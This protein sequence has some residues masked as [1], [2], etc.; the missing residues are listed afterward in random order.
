MGRGPRFTGEEKAAIWAGVAEGL[1]LEAVAA[2]MGRSESGIRYVVAQRGGVAPRFTEGTGRRLSLEEREEISRGLMAG[3]S[4][5]AIARGLERAVSTVSREVAANGGRVRYRACGA[6]RAACQRARRP[7]VAKLA[8][9]GPLRTAVEAMLC[10]RF[11]PQQI[12]GRLRELH[13]DNPEMWVSSETI[14][15]SLFIQGRGA[16]R[17][18][19]AENLR[20]GRHARRPRS[21]LNAKPKAKLPDPVPISQRP[22]EVEDRA[23]PGHWEGDLIFGKGQRD[24]MATLV[25]RTSRFV[26]LIALAEGHKAPHVRRALAAKIQQLPTELRRSL[27]WDRGT[28]MA[29]HV[30]FSIDTGV[31]VYFCDPR[32]PWQRGSNENTN[33]LLR[34]YFPKGKPLGIYDQAHLDTVAAEL[35]ERPRQTLGWA[36]PAE[37]LTEILATTG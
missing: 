26:M 10:K 23:V 7:R 17:R 9:P 19:L 37:K 29:E 35:N 6:H 22:P 25:E 24:A 12:S 28:E 20:S 13:P 15:Q 36:T 11:S 3:W 34:Q 4:L 33:G 14:Y 18:E 32:S 2:R 5:S 30:Q 31:D 27:T 16:L 8:R 21:R 1:T